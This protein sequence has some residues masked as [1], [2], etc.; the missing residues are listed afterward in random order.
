[1]Q[2]ALESRR[3]KVALEAARGLVKTA[4]GPESEALLLEAWFARAEELVGTG[5]RAEA[6]ELLSLVRTRFPTARA[7][8]DQVVLGLEV[9]FG[10]VEG[11]LRP[12][13][14][15]ALPA[16]RREALLELLRTSVR[17]PADVAGS[18]ALPADHP[19]RIEASAAAALLE[20]V[21]REPVDPRD[22]AF[23]K[24][25]RR[26]PFA[27]FVLLARAIDAAYRGDAAEVARV[28]ARIP[29]GTAPA[30]LSTSL[31]A[32]ALRRIGEDLGPADRRL[33][34]TVLGTDGRLARALA[35]LSA[36]IETES[37]GKAGRFA[38]E[39]FELIRASAPGLLPE[40]RRL[41]AID[42]VGLDLPIEPVGRI[43]DPRGGDPAEYYRVTALA[44]EEAS[45]PGEAIDLWNSWLEE[46]GRAATPAEVGAVRARQARLALKRA[47]L[48]E[49]DLLDGWIDDLEDQELR[50][51][52]EEIR[53]GLGHVR[54]PA[55]SRDADAIHFQQEAVKAVPSAGNFRDLHALVL[56]SGDRAEARVVAERWNE[57]FPADLDAILARARAE[58]ELGHRESALTLLDRAATL[59][60]HDPRIREARTASVL[61][62]LRAALRAGDRARARAQI[63]RLDGPGAPADED[64]RIVLGAA[65]WFAAE[66]P[67]QSAALDALARSIGDREARYLLHSA[68]GVLDDGRLAFRLPPRPPPEEP[69]VAAR[70]MALV[71]RAGRVLSIRLRPDP[72]YVLMLEASLAHGFVPEERDLIP[73]ADLF[74]AWGVREGLFHLSR[75]GLGTPSPRRH[76][77]LYYRALSLGRARGNTRRRREC[78]AA[79]AELSKR[80]GDDRTLRDAEA[81]LDGDLPGAGSVD[82]EAILAHETGAGPGDVRESPR[83]RKNPRQRSLF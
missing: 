27:P 70:A 72:P 37:A 60:P 10:N 39:V 80:V 68:A 58:A 16:D 63:A 30:R 45:D 46:R 52:L 14:D 64:L 59:A 35:D 22:E 24:V 1:V 38:T 18:A 11:L 20:R 9:G 3:G 6:L 2:A 34:T 49:A 47:S 56:S 36:L 21:A 41:L 48:D 50:E 69:A 81:H 65:R 17:D 83:G 32:I 33:V 79:A 26:S 54:K 76:R 71:G 74:V 75:A 25:P 42:W 15:P 28:V 5:F 31:E 19:L 44:C 73:L 29:A 51:S 53:A 67:E 61:G 62:E 12:L 66:A 82:S 13:A 7:R 55:R 43:L 78:L 4:P 77:F 57:A 40:F 23:T 8:V